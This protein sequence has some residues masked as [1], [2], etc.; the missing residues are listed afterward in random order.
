[1]E[2]TERA[3]AWFAEHGANV[4]EKKHDYLQKWDRMEANDKAELI[5]HAEDGQS[6][7]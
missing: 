5:L 7:Q 4:E 1:V 2:R 3:D 6:A